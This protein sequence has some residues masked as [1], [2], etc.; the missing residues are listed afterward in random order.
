[1]KIK[2][3]SY[4][5]LV[6]LITGILCSIYNGASA[7]EI[8]EDSKYVFQIFSKEVYPYL[9]KN[10]AECHS[11]S[12]T[13]PSGAFHSHSNPETAYSH[14]LEFINWNSPKDSQVLKR[15]N[16]G[17]FC[18]KYQSHCND[19]MVLQNQ[20]NEI[21]SSFINNIKTSSKINYAHLN[22][23]LSLPE[24]NQSHQLSTNYEIFYRKFDPLIPYTTD[25]ITVDK[26]FINSEQKSLTFILKP[27]VVP[28]YN[29]AEL[30][31]NLRLSLVADETYRI[32]KFMLYLKDNKLPQF[33]SLQGIQILINDHKLSY[34][35]TDKSSSFPYRTGWENADILTA[36]N[37]FIYDES[38]YF[39]GNTYT[40]MQVTLEKPLITI[41]EN[42]RVQ[43]SFKHLAV[44]NQASNYICN[45]AFLNSNL[46]L[47]G[48]SI[49]VRSALNMLSENLN[50]FKRDAENL[51]V[52]KYIES[53]INFLI[54]R[55]SPLLSLSSSISSD[56]NKALALIY[57]LVDSAKKMRSDLIKNNTVN[58]D[59]TKEIKTNSSL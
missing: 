56:S 4:L 7:Q 58:T 48:N 50:I 17:H 59:N 11:E 2:K 43:I 9:R 8:S 5:P 55:R 10:C 12:A 19:Q 27:N 40:G 47:E 3:I 41:H 31:I 38:F 34:Q 25:S 39:E 46:T 26:S 13:Y 1:M 32:N 33:I 45:E 37:K 57:S 20:G 54:P 14:F 28:A 23:F 6:I 29:Q 21:I 22:P 51:D 44:L 36:F 49:S 30:L 16:S 18:V 53:K 42:D 35:P 15:I 52:C 24:N